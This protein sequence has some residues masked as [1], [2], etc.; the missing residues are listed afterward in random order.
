[1]MWVS[2]TEEEL[3]KRYSPELQKKVLKERPQREREMQAFADQMREYSKSDRPS[4]SH[5]SRMDETTGKQC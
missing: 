1:M 2:P 5:E 3:F 4:T